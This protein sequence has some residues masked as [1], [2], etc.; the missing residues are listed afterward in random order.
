MFGQG[1]AGDET[2]QPEKVGRY[3]QASKTVADDEMKI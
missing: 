1:G 3:G 2:S